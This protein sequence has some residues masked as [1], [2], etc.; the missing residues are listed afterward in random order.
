MGLGHFHLPHGPGEKESFLLE[1]EGER[2]ASH[3][4]VAQHFWRSR[5][6]I[7]VLLF[8]MLLRHFCN[9]DLVAQ[10]ECT[11]PCPA[12]TAPPP[13]LC[14]CIHSLIHTLLKTQ[15]G[16]VLP[17]RPSWA[18]WSPSSFLRPQSLHRLYSACREHF[19]LYPL[20]G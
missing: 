20:S 18:S 10:P 11:S 14:S 13:P 9:R 1:L 7:I 4:L 17:C 15:D 19:S 6:M 5:N 3:S 12:P 16:P 2:R 8:R